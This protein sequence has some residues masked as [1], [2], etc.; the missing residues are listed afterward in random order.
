L[1]SLTIKEIAHRALLDLLWSKI[2]T[3]IV[4]Y[5]EM[6]FLGFLKD[7]MTTIQRVG[8]DVIHLAKW[9]QAGTAIWP[10]FP[11]YV[12]LSARMELWSHRLS[13]A[14]MEILIL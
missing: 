13:N 5:A 7:A 2:L 3:H 1:I 8:M 9:S 6:E 12:S 4:I 14:M 11:V 10:K